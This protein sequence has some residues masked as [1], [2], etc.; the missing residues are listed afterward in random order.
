MGSPQDF[1]A[2]MG[3]VFEGKLAPVVHEV[4]PLEEIR[5]AHEML[6]AGEVPPPEFTRHEIA[7]TLI[8]AM[9]S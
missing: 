7:E 6:E 1:R 4:M 3:L 8:K 2:V 9:K 5:R